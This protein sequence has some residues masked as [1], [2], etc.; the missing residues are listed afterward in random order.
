MLTSVDWSPDSRR[1]VSGGSDGTARLGARG[2]PDAGDRRGRGPPGVPPV[3]RADPVGDGR[4][5]L[6]GRA[7]CHHRRPRDRRVKSGICR[8]RAT[9]RSTTSRRPAPGTGRGRLPPGRPD[10]RSGRPRVRRGL[11]GRATRPSPCDARPRDGA[12]GTPVV[13]VDPSPDGELVAMVPGFSNVVSVWNVETSA[14]AFDFDIE[15]DEPISSMDWSGDGRYLAE[16]VRRKRARARR[17]RRRAPHARRLRSERGDASP[18]RRTVGRSRSGPSTTRSRTPT[19]CRSGIGVRARSFG[20][21][22]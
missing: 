6:A 20:S 14:L 9:P 1:I 7:G 11:G 15:G 10:R 13:R 16:R 5:V 3:G 22:M 19:T 12:S 21:S 18:S 2:A 4:G 17:R 8:S